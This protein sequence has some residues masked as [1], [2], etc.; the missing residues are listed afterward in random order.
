MFCAELYLYSETEVH[1]N[2]SLP[3]PTVCKRRRS[4]HVRAPV[5]SGRD[6]M[7]IVCGDH[8]GLIIDR[9]PELLGDEGARSGGLV[10]LVDDAIAGGSRDKAVEFL[11]LEASHGRI[12]SHNGEFPAPSPVP[13]LPF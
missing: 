8:F 9:S 2:L 6:A 11:S 7:L 3:P 5:S 4:E 13:H 10:A 12:S 1:R